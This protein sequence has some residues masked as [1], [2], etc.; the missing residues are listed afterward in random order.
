MTDQLPQNTISPEEISAAFAQSFGTAVGWLTFEKLQLE[1]Q[2]Q[3]LRLN[4]DGAMK[5]IDDLSHENSNLITNHIQLEGQLHSLEKELEERPTL[6]KMRELEAEV[7]QLIEDATLAQ[8][9]GQEMA[10]A[11]AEKEKAAQD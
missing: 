3:T 7:A 4:L 5:T 6:G 11:E 8:M 2:M 10:R 1:R 9:S